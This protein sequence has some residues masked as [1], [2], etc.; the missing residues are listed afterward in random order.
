MKSANP[1]DV[2][3]IDAIIKAAYEVISGPTG[4][5]RDWDRERSLYLPGARLIPKNKAPG[6]TAE[7]GP[8]GILDVDGFIKRVEPFFETSGFY[9]MEVARQTYQFGDIAHAWSTYE[10]RRDPSDP[11][12]FMRGINSIQ[13]FF[14]AKR[15]WIVTIYWQ[16]ESPEQPIP[17]EYLP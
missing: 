8:L 4:V 13:L 5:K 10:S 7:A 11:D 16:Q 2:E 12:P 3:S 9:E 15:W 17:A 6:A 14:D 1:K